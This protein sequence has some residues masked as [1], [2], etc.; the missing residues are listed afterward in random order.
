MKN[1]RNKLLF[2]LIL[3]IIS[4]FVVFGCS[5]NNQPATQ[6]QSEEKKQEPKIDYPKGN[7]QTIVSYSAGG[8]TD[9]TARIVASFLEKELGKSVIVVNKPG[10]KGELGMTETANGKPDGYNLGF[11]SYPDNVLMSS[12]KETTYDNSKLKYIASFTQS[13]TVLLIKK[14]SPYSTIEEFI[15]YAKE[16]PGKISVAVGGD[17]HVYSVMQL[18]KAAEIELQTVMFSSGSK[19][20][21]AAVGGHT[22]AAFVAIQF[23]LASQEQGCKVIGSAGNERTNNLADVPTFIEKGYDVQ[24]EMMRILATPVGTPDEIVNILKEACDQVSKSQEYIDKLG[25]TGEIVKYQS[26]PQ[27]EEFL[28]KSDAKIKEVVGENKDMFLRGA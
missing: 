24:A 20:M 1:Q 7:I 9:T 12:Y 26:G 28:K 14:D 19:A 16:N 10:A 11:I 22:D 6:N 15:S 8:G 21:N 27:L 3:V 2:I 13:P 23:G 18:E 17:G 5:D 25:N 4:S